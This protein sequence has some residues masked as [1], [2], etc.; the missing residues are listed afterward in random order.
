M[1]SGGQ[2]P[3]FSLLPCRIPLSSYLRIRDFSQDYQFCLFVYLSVFCSIKGHL[4]FELLVHLIELVEEGLRI[5]IK[6]GAA[7]VEMWYR[8]NYY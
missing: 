6:E 1:I 8:I 2:H 4:T 5:R 7:P 3:R